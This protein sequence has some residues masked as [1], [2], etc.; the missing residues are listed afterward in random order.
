MTTIPHGSDFSDLRALFVNTSLTRDPARSHTAALMSACSGLMRRAGAQVHTVHAAQH[1]IAMGVQA[2]MREHGAP[3]D[4]WPALWPRVLESDILV[5]GTPLWLGEESSLCRV[6]IERL[7]AMSGELNGKG[8][9]IFYGKVGGAVVTGNEDGVKHAAMTLTFA[10]SHLGY[11]VPPQADCGWLGEI[12]PGPSYGD[13]VGEGAGN[14]EP[15]GFANDF[16]QRNATIM[17]Y[18][19]LHTARLL[20]DAG[21]LPNYG[22]DRRA[23]EDGERFGFQ[24]PL[25][26]ASVDMH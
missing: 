15:V 24:N 17:T 13:I 8:Q 4:A 1:R 10:L 5:I 16:T 11:T 22:N 26:P 14:G 6:V 21:G 2:D 9:S 25:P 3:E 7:Y 23:W 20:K 19:L 12:G 18:N